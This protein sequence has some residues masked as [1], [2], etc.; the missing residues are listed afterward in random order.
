MINYKRL[1]RFNQFYQAINVPDIVFLIFS[2]SASSRLSP[3]PHQQIIQEQNVY[4]VDNVDPENG[5]L[6]HLFSKKVINFR[7]KETI[8]SKLTY[9][10]KNEE[11][12]RLLYMKSRADFDA[13]L[14]ALRLSN[15]S[16]IADKLVLKS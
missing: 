15:Q 13:F 2:G 1:R 10:V 14:E 8:A 9:F 12:L 5:L 7:E 11:L 6:N 4:L 3:L 16:H